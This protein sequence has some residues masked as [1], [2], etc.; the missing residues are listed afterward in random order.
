MEDNNYKQQIEELEKRIKKIE[1]K[2]Y[3]DKQTK[4]IIYAI[5]AVIIIGVFIFAYFYYKNIYN[6]IDI[7][8]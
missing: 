7:L 6:I 2:M 4:K 1:D 8:R 5:Y 3:H